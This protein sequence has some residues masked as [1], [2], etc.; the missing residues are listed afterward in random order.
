M[1]GVRGCRSGK[2]AQGGTS[3]ANSSTF[4]P[5][6]SVAFFGDRA[7]PLFTSAR[8]T[9]GFTTEPVA[10]LWRNTG[11]FAFFLRDAVWK[12]AEGRIEGSV[13][14]LDYDHVL[15]VAKPARCRGPSA[16]PDHGLRVGAQ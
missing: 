4:P 16:T 6:A 5:L 15:N 14:L 12:C 7:S 1:E 13:L 3:L 9:C 11:G 10:G 2:L 8:G